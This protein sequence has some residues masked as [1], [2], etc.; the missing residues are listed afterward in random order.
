VQPEFARAEDFDTLTAKWR[1][2]AR[3]GYGFTDWRWIY[4]AQTS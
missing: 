2:Y 1:A 3:W 4:G